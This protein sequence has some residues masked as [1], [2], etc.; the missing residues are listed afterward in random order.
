MK[1]V[2]NPLSKNQAVLIVD[3][4]P[5]LLKTVT[6]ML[7][8]SGYSKVFQATNGQDCVQLAQENVIDIILLDISMPGISGMDACR[9]LRST[10]TNKRAHIIAC[11]AHADT[12]HRETFYE[13]GFN[14]ILLKPFGYPELMDKLKGAPIK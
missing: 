8:R 10:A 5:E 4:Y 13:A 7:R 1:T 9:M 12:R 3:D 6:R 2:E 11:T 14:D